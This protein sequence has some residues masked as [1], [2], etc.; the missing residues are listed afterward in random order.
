M[1]LSKKKVAILLTVVSPSVYKT[2]R[3]LCDQ[4]LPESKTF[5][6]LD[7]L[8]KRHFLLQRA[9][10]RE[11]VKFYKTT[12]ARGERI[13]DWYA[14]I[15]SLS[16]T[17]RFGANLEEV[18]KD[19]LIT[20]LSDSRILNRLC[21]EDEQRTLKELFDLAVKRESEEAQEVLS[22]QTQKKRTEK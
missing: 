3:D 4:Q 13:A 1:T 22:I 12:Q 8:L 7:D 21:E 17:Y 2:L 10:Y 16:V 9:V 14:R 11:R 5:R 6:Q 19:R 15:K 18:L 20:G